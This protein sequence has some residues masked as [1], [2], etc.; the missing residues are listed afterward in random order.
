MPEIQTIMRRASTVLQDTGSTRWTYP[1]MLDWI[2]D[3]ITEIANFAPEL[4]AEIRVI[5]LVAGP[6]QTIP[7]DTTKM[8]RAICNVTGSGAPYTRGAVITPISHA[9]LA[10]QLPN[11]QDTSRLP[12]SAIVNHIIYDPL[13]PRSFY[14]VPGNN[15]SGKIECAFSTKPTPIAQPANPLTLASYTAS[16]PIEDVYTNAVLDY[17]LYRALQKEL[18]VPGAAEKAAM[19]YQAFSAAIGASAQ[20]MNRTSP[21]T[22]DPAKRQ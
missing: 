15:G 9:I 6:L 18:N 22:A 17:V 20:A 16:L 7:N 1:E 14:V 2:N 11:W 8:L 5:T 10:A 19:H 4:L 12:Y 21:S 3:S 13:T